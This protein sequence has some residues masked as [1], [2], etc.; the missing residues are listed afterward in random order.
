MFA[1]SSSAGH[2][3]DWGSA[4]SLAFAAAALAF[5]VALVRC[6]CDRA[7]LF[8]RCRPFGALIFGVIGA[9][10]LHAGSHRADLRITH[11][12][13]FAFAGAA[14][15][16]GLAAWAASRVPPLRFDAEQ[17]VTPPAVD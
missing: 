7:R 12:F 17:P 4:T 11:A 15:L 5:A 1:A 9:A 6:G 2:R 14:L 3:F 8:V 10:P 13:R 16:S